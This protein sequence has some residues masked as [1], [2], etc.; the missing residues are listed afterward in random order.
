MALIISKSLLLQG[1]VPGITG[2]LVWCGSGDIRVR[3]S[4]ALEANL[5]TLRER[6]GL[7]CLFI[8]Q[9]HEENLR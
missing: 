7:Q 8:L 4:R 3:I 9:T 6:L 2:Q 1:A 5:G